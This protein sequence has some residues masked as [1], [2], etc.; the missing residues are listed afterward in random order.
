MVTY[1]KDNVTVPESMC[2]NSIAKKTMNLGLYNLDSPES[3]SHRNFFNRKD[4][5]L[6]T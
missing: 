1:L 3:I 2:K 6:I 4:T 5:L